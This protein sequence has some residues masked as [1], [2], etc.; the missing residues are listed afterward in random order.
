MMMVDPPNCN[1][2]PCVIWFHNKN[3]HIVLEYAWGRVVSFISTTG[4]GCAIETT[5]IRFQVSQLINQIRNVADDQ[6]YIT[7]KLTNWR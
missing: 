6:T 1:Y 2:I 4:V 7:S 5:S 3:D